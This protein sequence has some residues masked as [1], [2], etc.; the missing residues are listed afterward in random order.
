MARFYGVIGFAIQTETKPGVW[1]DEIIV[2][3]Y[4]GDLLKNTAKWQSAP[5]LNDNLDINNTISI[6]A[7]PYAELNYQQIK[8]VEW[9]GARW[10]V[11]RVEVQYPRLHLYL[12]GVYNG[13]VGTNKKT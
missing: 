4:Y 5:S 13:P 6:L 10:K 3:E 12:G 11:V 7:D 1:K 9:M 8:Y 2:K